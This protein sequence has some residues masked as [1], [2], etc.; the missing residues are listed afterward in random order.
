MGVFFTDWSGPNQQVVDPRKS[1]RLYWFYYSD[2]TSADENPLQYFK[3]YWKPTTVKGWTDPVVKSVY[4]DKSVNFFY[5][6]P[7]TFTLDSTWAFQVEAWVQDKDYDPNA[8]TT[9]PDTGAPITPVS[10]DFFVQSSFNFVVDTSAYMMDVEKNVTTTSGS[11]NF[12]FVSQLASGFTTIPSD[13]GDYEVRF[14]V[15]NGFQWSNWSTPVSL[16]QYDTRKWVKRAG[17]I[18]WAVPNWK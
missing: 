2:S 11:S 12:T 17:N 9:D 10:G 15:S 14:K 6:S 1:I 18:W 5:L 7:N 16:K 4:V 8:P 13:P 3:L